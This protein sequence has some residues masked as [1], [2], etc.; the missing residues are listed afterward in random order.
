ME[1]NAGLVSIED[2][3]AGSLLAWEPLRLVILVRLP[4]RQLL[5]GE[6]HAVVVIEFTPEG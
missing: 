4:L 5:P 6:R 3:D 1:D 2:A